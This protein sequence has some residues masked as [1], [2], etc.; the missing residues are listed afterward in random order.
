M[1][2]L[3]SSRSPFAIGATNG[4]FQQLSNWRY[5]D[6]GVLTARSGVSALSP[7]IHFTASGTSSGG[8]SGTTLNAL[9]VNWGVNS[10]ANAVVAVVS[11][12][13]SGEER[14]VVSNTATQLTVSSPWT[15]IPDNTSVYVV[16]A[17]P[18]SLDTL[19][20]QGTSSIIAGL[21][22]W[23]TAKTS[24]WRSSD[25]TSFTEITATSGKY[26]NTR[27]EADSSGNDYGTVVVSC[28]DRFTGKDCLVIQNGYASPRVY[29]GVN[30]AVNQA[31]SSPTFGSGSVS[32]IKPYGSFVMN[33]SD[34]TFFTNSADTG[35][36]TGSNTTT[37]LHDTG[38][39]WTVN[40]WAGA[41]VTITQGTGVGESAVIL[42]NTSTVLTLV[43]AW[44]GA[45]P[46]NTSHYSISTSVNWN[47]AWF[48]GTSGNNYTVLT[49]SA[50]TGLSGA[51]V[52]TGPS[53]SF[54]ISSETKQIFLTSDV[55]TAEAIDFLNTFKI[56]LK[57]H[58]SGTYYTIYDPSQGSSYNSPP[59]SVGAK[60]TNT[61]ALTIWAFPADALVA[62]GETIIDAIRITPISGAPAMSAELG[63]II[64]GLNTGGPWPGATSFSVA[65][66]NSASR[67]ESANH[68]LPESSSPMANY[69]MSSVLGNLQ[70]PNSDQLFYAVDVY[71]PQQTQSEA[72]NGTDTARIY[73]EETDET[74]YTYVQSFTIAT[75]NGSSWVR[76]SPFGTSGLYLESLTNGPTDRLSWLNSPSDFIAPIPVGRALRNAT[77]Q[78]LL[79]GARAATD[80]SFPWVQTS[81]GGFP[82]RFTFAPD[83]TDPLTAYF[84]QIS[85]EN[86][87]A[88][89]NTAASSYAASTTYCF[90]DKSIWYVNFLAIGTPGFLSRI[91]SVG[92]GSPRSVAEHRGRISFVDTD[93]R[94]QMFE[95]SYS[96]PISLAYIDDVFQAVPT[97]RLRSIVSTWFNY[98][99]FNAL[100][101]SGTLNRN[102]IIFA[103]NGNGFRGT[104]ESNDSYPAP[105]TVEGLVNWHPGT[106]AQNGAYGVIGPGELV[107]LGSDCKT[108]KMENGTTD[109]GSN[110]TCTMQTGNLQTPWMDTPNAQAGFIFRRVGVMCDAISTSGTITRTY[111]QRGS[112]GIST[113]DLTSASPFTWTWDAQQAPVGDNRGSAGNL[114]LSFPLTGGKQ[115]HGIQVEVEAATDGPG[116]Q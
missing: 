20:F 36:S 14:V 81:E 49:T 46:D 71:F 90:T 82:F 79:V 85:G 8:N 22:D 42:S 62:A 61:G 114:T 73:A 76:S 26:G 77:G 19:S 10:F 96:R 97:S 75:W 32:K 112:T 5:A 47:W 93:Q 2:G 38:K 34:V 102:A 40:Q 24:V 56:E 55:T 63:I 69:G 30:C 92:T 21:R 94:C 57:G 115:F 113:I 105:F 17:N 66:Y 33:D 59:I 106:T 35:I 95:G 53:L 109:L 50:L 110:I 31:I 15:L 43:A 9:G 84:D 108:Y 88:F 45:T 64:Y 44:S 111:P 39:T 6:E 107:A 16:A 12:T 70:F 11:G 67:A 98:R 58:T 87:Q 41:T 103:E 37:T 54:A 4:L 101:Q 78:R 51:I 48:G 99:F 91:A 116:G 23:D 52:L 74:S 86:I 68:V 28:F 89:V 18:R 25:S 100:T 3:A 83:E 60:V 72:N 13:G 7:V 1:R 65:Y 80:D 27:L 29:D 104:W